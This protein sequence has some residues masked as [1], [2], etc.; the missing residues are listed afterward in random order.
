MQKDEMLKHVKDWLEENIGAYGF[1][2][3]S[4]WTCNDHCA[5]ANLH[6]TSDITNILECVSEWASNLEGIWLP[7]NAI[8]T[9]WVLDHNPSFIVLD[10]KS[11]TIQY[12][13]SIPDAR[14]G[15]KWR[16]S[17]VTIAVGSRGMVMEQNSL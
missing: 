10:Y 9:D 12:F 4:N 7:E 11:I 1:I 14:Y 8:K 2:L 17:K 3:M 5:Y 16:D 15:Y 13:V 6:P